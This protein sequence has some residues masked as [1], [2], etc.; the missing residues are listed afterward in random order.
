MYIC[1]FIFMIYYSLLIWV[2]CYLIAFR[3]N[4]KMY[5][6]CHTNI[7]LLKP[8]ILWWFLTDFHQTILKSQY[9]HVLPILKIKTNKLLSDSKPTFVAL[10]LCNYM[11]CSILF[12]FF[13]FILKLF[14]RNT[15]FVLFRSYWQPLW[16]LFFVSVLIN[17]W[18][19]FGGFYKHINLTK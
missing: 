9:R 7:H 8:Y 16:F 12:V 13:L 6:Y 4:K 19:I 11:L 10:P 3:S 17:Y 2:S 14:F 18:I 1:I 15:K 5:V